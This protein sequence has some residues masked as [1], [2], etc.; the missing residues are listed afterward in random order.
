MIIPT[1][2][3]SGNLPYV[4]NTIPSWVDE[5]IVVDGRSSDDT[6]RV[7]R[8]LR[9][10]VRIIEQRRPGKGAALQAGFAAAT[11]KI[12]IALDADGSMD[13]G[14]IG[15]FRDALI[16]GA[17]YVK[18]CRFCPGGGSNDIT[19][20]RRMGDRGICWLIHLLF[21][22]KYVDATYGYIGFWADQMDAIGI[23][24]DGFG[25]ETL[26]GIRAYRA[27]L[28]T[29]EVP[30]FEAKRIY[31]KSNLSAMR[32][33]LRIIRVILEERLH[34]HRVGPRHE[35]VSEVN[36][37]GERRGSALV[38]GP[39]SSLTLPGII[40]SEVAR[41]LSGATPVIRIE[42]DADP[43]YAEGLTRSLSLSAAFVE[44]HSDMLTTRRAPMSARL[45][46]QA[47]DDWLGPDIRVAFA[48]AWPSLDN[49]WIRDFI[50]S[51]KAARVPCAV[52][53][54]GLSKSENAT[55]V[56]V[57]EIVSKADLVLVG[58]SLEA[59]QYSAAFAASGP[60][61][62]VHRSLSLKGRADQHSTHRVTA[63]L[64]KDSTETLSTLLAAFDAIPHS[65]IGQYELQIAMRFTSQVIPEMIT[66]SFHG[67]YVRLL[68]ERISDEELKRMCEASSALIIADP[69]V[70]SRVFQVAVECGIAT[71]VL[72]PTDLPDVGVGYVGGLLADINFPAAIDVAL[73]H[74]LRLAELRFPSPDAWAELAQ[75]LNVTPLV[76]EHVTDASTPVE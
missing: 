34:R 60:V 43:D 11:G 41:A 56:E 50:H 2:N 15:A 5:V 25:V 45:R 70:N 42:V 63:F 66:G 37:L 31:G 30:C 49:A 76:D 28:R 53:I 74:A 26:I 8:A 1:L 57:A 21:G 14:A 16:A 51:A 69:L 35:T 17:D 3:E 27:G 55:I 72:S 19:W 73:A 58:D 65:W 75:R 29:A 48:Y 23:D 12:L 62:E 6:E 36:S 40:V 39:G 32:D 24:T 7:A 9:A 52:A 20:L 59:S 71:I 46:K 22:A 54:A 44:P 10:D 4:L 47:F 18:G 67:A 68:D 38:A 61:V 13:G 33:G 64:P